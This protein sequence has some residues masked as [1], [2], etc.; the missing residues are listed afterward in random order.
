M[1]I[2]KKAILTLLLFSV[3]SLALFSFPFS[4]LLETDKAYEVTHSESDFFSVENFKL[5]KGTISIEVKKGYALLGNTDKGYTEAIIL[6]E[7][8]RVTGKAQHIELDDE[9]QNLYL[10]F[11][12]KWYEKNLAKSLKKHSPINELYDRA[13]AI[14]REKFQNYFHEGWKAFILADTVLVCDFNIKPSKLRIGAIFPMNKVFIMTKLED[15]WN[16][17]EKDNFIIYYPDNSLVKDSL[18]EW[19]A[20]REKAFKG[21]CDYLGVSKDERSKKVTFYIFNDREQLQK[22]GFKSGH[23]NRPESKIYTLANQSYGHELTHILCQRVSSKRSSF[24]FASEGLATFLD[25]SGRNYNRISKYFLEN[26]VVKESELTKLLSNDAFN[27]LR[28]SYCFASS[29]VEYLIEEYSLEKFKNFYMQDEYPINE[30]FEH[31]Y[32]KEGEELLESWKKRILN[33]DYGNLTKKEKE[34]YEKGKEI[35][36]EMGMW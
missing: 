2:F 3:F 11:N 9:I 7:D 31:F 5:E 13:V 24:A 30:A 23:A 12:P 36:K 19:L 28:F 1:R 35:M 4:N 21:I 17:Y 14:H 16:K 33:T 27:E 25:Q 29:F 10:R 8:S 6:P 22:F 32:K 26:G 34:Y 20:P 15:I 18:D